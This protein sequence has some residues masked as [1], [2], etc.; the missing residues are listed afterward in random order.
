MNVIMNANMKIIALLFCLSLSLPGAIAQDYILLWP[1][2]KMP[3]S[4]GIKMTDSIS[5]ERIRRV[6]K[7][8]MWVF[9]P[10]I[11]EN[12]GV[13]VIICP[14]GGYKHYAYD[15]SGFQI[16]KWFNT[17]GITA[18]VL[19]ARFPHSPDL[20]E[21][22]S[23][24][25]QDAQRALRIIRKDAATWEINTKKIGIIGFSAGGHLASTLGTHTKDVSKIN[26][27]L[28]TVSFRPDFMM[29]ISPVITMG[30]Y[31]H[32]G[33]RDNL[34]GSKPSAELL[35]MYSNELHVTTTTPPTFLVHAD[36]DR[37]VEARNSILFY[38]A[39]RDKKIPASLHIFPFGGHNIAL[40]N[41]PGSANSWSSLCEQW[42]TEIDVMKSAGR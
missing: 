20:I 22:H 33:S 35:A 30:P 26:D 17:M 3:N 4:K 42:L 16:A 23:A 18:F 25:L 32:E 24:P 14:G 28:D 13:A 37:T 21:R 29:L 11:Q 12:K 27:P 9:K 5:D 36:D 10:S 41:N 15:I 40:R 7:P 34:L 8:G 2:G 31:T 6:G 1:E 38:T 39:L 19:N